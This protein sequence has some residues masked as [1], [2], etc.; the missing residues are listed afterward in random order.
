MKKYCINGK[1][2]S[3]EEQKKHCKTCDDGKCYKDEKNLYKTDK[4]ALDYTEKGCCSCLSTYRI[5]RILTGLGAD[6]IKGNDIY[7]E[8]LKNFDFNTDINEKN[9]IFFILKTGEEYDMEVIKM[10]DVPKLR[11]QFEETK[12]CPEHMWITSKP[13]KTTE[14]TFTIDN[15]AIC[16]KGTVIYKGKVYE[17]TL[18]D[19]V[20]MIATAGIH[21]QE[22]T[23]AIADTFLNELGLDMGLEEEDEELFGFL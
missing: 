6:S 5:P 10:K 13:F 2:K 23:T 9:S 8:D 15:C 18:S 14:G 1:V 21:Y 11:E 4:Y 19:L 22:K 16:K 17:G 20:N 12:V 7:V 3:K